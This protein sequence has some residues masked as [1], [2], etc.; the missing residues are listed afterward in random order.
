MNDVGLEKIKTPLL[1]FCF[2]F[3]V[4]MRIYVKNSTC[5][6]A[7]ESLTGKIGSSD[8]NDCIATALTLVLSESNRDGYNTSEIAILL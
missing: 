4:N 7:L 6:A 5:S 8:V 1:H 3:F 2:P